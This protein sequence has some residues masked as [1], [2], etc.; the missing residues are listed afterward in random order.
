MY[1]EGDCSR[2]GMDM[3]LDGYGLILVSVGSEGHGFGWLSVTGEFDILE[4][5]LFTQIA[6]ATFQILRRIASF[7]SVHFWHFQ[8]DWSYIEGDRGLGVF[9]MG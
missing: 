2:V 6:Y 1:G 8:A 9:W 5:V 3:D 7:D 4:F